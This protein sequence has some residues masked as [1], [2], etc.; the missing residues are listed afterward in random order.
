MALL[1]VCALCTGF[2]SAQDSALD[3][4]SAPLISRQRQGVTQP[5]R[6]MLPTQRS[7]PVTRA[8]LMGGMI[9]RLVKRTK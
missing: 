1:I 7:G 6:T 3:D 5:I 8:G 9:T 4:A 2:A